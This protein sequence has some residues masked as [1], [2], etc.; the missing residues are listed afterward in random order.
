MWTEGLYDI[1]EALSYTEG[2]CGELMAIITE[3]DFKK[4][5]AIPETKLEARR[6]FLNKLRGSC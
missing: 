2:E 1:F 6:T 4:L 5:V 3:D